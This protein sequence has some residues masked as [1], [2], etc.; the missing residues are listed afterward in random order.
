MNNLTGLLIFSFCAYLAGIIA[1]LI[2]TKKAARFFL[3]FFG[4]I[5]SIGLFITGTISLF[6]NKAYHTVL[7]S[8]P[9]IGKLAIYI[10]HLSSLF[11]IVIS[12]LFIA[13]S[14]FSF[15]YLKHYK[16]KIN[17]KSF[18][19]FYFILLASVAAIPIT[20]DI[21]SFLITWEIMSVV[22]Y[23]L[24]ITEYKSE[25]ARRAGYL[26]LSIG[27]VGTLFIAVAFIILAKFAG[28]T[29]FSVIKHT[30]FIF[31]PFLTWTVFLL[32]F[33]GFA[34]KVGLVPVN[35]W[36]PRA[37]PVAPANI[38]ALL[39]GIIL[40][41]GLY[42]ILRTDFN[43]F[44]IV[45][46]GPGIVIMIIG[47]IS[48]VVGILYATIENDIKRILAHS[49]IENMGIISVG[50]GASLI[51]RSTGHPVYAGIALIAALFHMINHS[52]YKGL[53]FIVAGV[54]DTHVGSR[55]LDKLGGLIKLMPWTGLFAL[56]G[57]LSISAMPPFNG[58]V[59]E[60][61]TFEALLRSVELGSLWVKMVFV[62]AGVAL[63]L[64]AGL[65]VTCFVRMFSMG[66]LGIARS[67]KIKNLKEAGKTALVSLGIL[68]IICLILGVLPT[69]FIPKIDLAVKPLT[70]AYATKALIPPFFLKHPS[71][72]E[73]PPNFA[74]DFHKLGAQVGKSIIHV[75]G[76][77]IIHRGGKKN[78]VVYAMSSSYMFVTLIL[79]LAIT[80]FIIWLVVARRRKVEYR[81]QWDG[82]VKELF[83]EMTY[84]ATGFAQPVRVIFE[85]IFRPK[86]EE[87][88]ET[89]GKYFRIS[90]KRKQKEIHLI[91]R[92]VLYPLT[93]KGKQI[94]EILA[95]MHNG[96]L[97][98]YVVYVLLTLII[99]FIVGLID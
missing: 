26:M 31:N 97:N 69:Y 62:L 22:C 16:L 94:A 52:I 33:L 95:K 88:H 67:E 51:F 89:V 19:F 65:A 1:T 20:G 63:A 91:D 53:L 41:L 81:P 23:I 71:P 4:V 47:A 35:F 93:K 50:L 79:F 48:A 21:F 32:S 37:H 78:P 61:L 83:P 40:N 96:K 60:W 92:L 76:L 27:E 39:S 59:S 45:T 25:K 56:I 13:V 2:F 64:T 10:D 72:K 70:G 74:S 38:S 6:A 80:A 12:I 11:L 3:S 77:A 28:S 98:A 87:H 5:G 14:I 90:I 99:F 34:T 30:S 86:I 24:V 66:F 18:G 57:V 84:T 82:G 75:R 15:D 8:I 54:V 43:F 17:L 55:D 73:L 9:D 85:P 36:L 58:F 46:S 49:S 42:G 7:W 29:D 44:Y 68:S